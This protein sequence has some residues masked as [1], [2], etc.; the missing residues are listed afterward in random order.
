MAEATQLVSIF[1]KTR[2]II[3]CLGNK[4]LILKRGSDL[5]YLQLIWREMENLISFV[6]YEDFWRNSEDFWRFEL[7]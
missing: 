2:N 7:S 4:R 1:L 5:I 6:I 3:S